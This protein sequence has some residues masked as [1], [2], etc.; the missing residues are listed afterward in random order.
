MTIFCFLKI[1]DKNGMITNWNSTL[2]KCT[3]SINERR[4]ISDCTYHPLFPKF[5]SYGNNGLIYVYDEE[6]QIFEKV[7]NNMN[8]NPKTYQINCCLF[9]PNP[10]YQH[11]I[12]TG[13]E[14]LIGFWDL[15]Q[16]SA[17]RSINDHAVSGHGLDI[18]RRT[19]VVQIKPKFPFVF[20]FGHFRHLNL[21]KTK[22][23]LKSC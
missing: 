20:L 6:R 5:L 1:V 19:N 15:R 4:A 9:H 14:N 11:E 21:C 7:L 16:I 18:N 23:F 13:S 12:I 17:V 8:F 2:N 22:V 10:I 3:Y